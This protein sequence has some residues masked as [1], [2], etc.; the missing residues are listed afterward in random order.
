MKYCKVELHF[1]RNRTTNRKL[2]A[3]PF[4]NQ[5]PTLFRAIFS[6][7]LLFLKKEHFQSTSPITKEDVQNQ[8]GCSRYT[9]LERRFS[10]NHGFTFPH[11]EFPI[12]HFHRCFK[13]PSEINTNLFVSYNT[14]KK[15]NMCN[16]AQMQKFAEPCY[17]F[18][19]C[20]EI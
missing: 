9:Y 15:C 19:F 7:S 14:S 17:F 4:P 20:N 12:Y 10:S 5:F 3:P 1:D 6:F 13:Q 8:R 11:F 16:I 18:N 2:K